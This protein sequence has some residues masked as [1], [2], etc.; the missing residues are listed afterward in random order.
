MAKEK[1]ILNVGPA[2]GIYVS[3]LFVPMAAQQDEN[4]QPKYSVVLLAEKNGNALPKVFAD[5]AKAVDMVGIKQFGNKWKDPRFVAKFKR[6]IRDGD[7]EKPDKDLFA[8]KAFVTLR[9]AYAP[10]VITRTRKQVTVADVAD[11]GE[12]GEDPSTRIFSGCKLICSVAVDSFDKQSS[13]GV[14]LYLRSVLLWDNTGDVIDLGGPDPEKDFEKHLTD[15][16][17]S[18]T[19]DDLPF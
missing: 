11:R 7:T 10:K 6:P 8:G 17:S 12:G 15:S 13:Q 3:N 5:L 2:T 9:T 1:V 19:D 14:T 18:G 16:D 4:A